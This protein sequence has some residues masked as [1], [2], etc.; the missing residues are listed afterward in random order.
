MRCGEY[1]PR[2][3]ERVP[4]DSRSTSTVRN[5]HGFMTVGGTVSTATG[6]FLGW[7]ARVR[8]P[9]KSGGDDQ[10]YRNYASRESNAVL[11]TAKATAQATA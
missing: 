2:D 1:D 6:C 11:N 5:V 3:V 8:A 10:T 7:R 9:E 4:R